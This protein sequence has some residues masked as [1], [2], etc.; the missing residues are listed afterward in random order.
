MYGQN[1][2]AY[3]YEDRDNRCCARFSLWA[4]FG[5]NGEDEVKPF[6]GVSYYHFCPK[7][8]RVPAPSVSCAALRSLS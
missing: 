7:F 6:I 3:Y 4:C 8:T 1:G 5:W 2:H